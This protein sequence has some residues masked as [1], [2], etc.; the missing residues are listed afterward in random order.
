MQTD[1]SG[2]KTQ[3]QSRQ[4]RSPRGGGGI[5]VKPGTTVAGYRNIQNF[6]QQAV[7]STQ[8]SDRRS[9]MPNINVQQLISNIP[10]LQNL[11]NLN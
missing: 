8:Q 3:S 9:R 10:E 6:I 1:F 5:Q 2:S 7:P 4:F 11:M